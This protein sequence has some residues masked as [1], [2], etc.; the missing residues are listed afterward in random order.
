[1]IDK[2][3]LFSNEITQDAE[4]SCMAIFNLCRVGIAANDTTMAVD[5]RKGGYDSLFEAIAALAEDAIE[6]LNADGQRIDRGG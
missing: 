1:M 4:G 3:A 2:S 5:L 6:R